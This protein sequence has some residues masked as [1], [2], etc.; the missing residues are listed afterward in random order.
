MNMIDVS[1]T[2]I[3]RANS[4]HN[5][6]THDELEFHCIH[7]Q[8][9]P[10]MEFTLYIQPI[11]PCKKS[12]KEEIHERQTLKQKPNLSIET[13]SLKPSKLLPHWQRLPKWMKKFRRPI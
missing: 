10:L 1:T 13:I 11:Q 12:N 7:C 4:P 8:D 3:Y 2:T 5:I 9:K 6:C